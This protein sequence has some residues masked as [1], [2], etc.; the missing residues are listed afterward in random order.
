MQTDRVNRRDTNSS[1]NDVFDLLQFAVERIVCLDDLF[2]V[3]VKHL[4][5]ASEAKF[6]FAAFDQEGLELPF[7]GTDLL[8]DR[9]L[10]DGVYLGGF[11]E[12]FSF[13]EIAEHFETF[14]LH[15]V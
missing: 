5:F 6:L 11:C 15:T 2:A 8:A 12:A 3:L 14:Y 1:G 10:G 4:P 7:E 9:R 13:R